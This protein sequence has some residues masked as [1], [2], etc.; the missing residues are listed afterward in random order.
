MLPWLVFGVLVSGMLLLDLGLLH[1]EPKALTPKQALQ[2]TALWMSLAAMFNLGLFYF[3]GP[4]MGLEFLTGY[5]IE[6]SL[7]LDNIFVFLL[8]F[9]GLNIQAKDQHRILVWGVLG[10]LVMRAVFIAGGL[11]LLERF[12]WVGIIFGVILLATAI[13]LLKPSQGEFNLQKNWFGKI[14]HRILPMSPVTT[15]GAFFT[16]QGRKLQFT[17]LF[18]A[19]LM[20]EF[21]DL[22][23]ALDSIPAVLAVSHHGLIVFTSNIFAIL[24]LRSLYFAIAAWVEKLRHLH[25]ILAALLGFISFKMLAEPFFKISTEISLGIIGGILLVAVGLTFRGLKATSH[26][27]VDR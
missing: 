7:S 4:Q 18:L 9:R 19:L 17:P 26:T 12:S 22:I 21:S 8:I 20:I 10:A 24:G 1:R 6:K 14:L 3:E 16:F 5:L 23:F 13:R 11:E 27:T 2:W 15:E 25:L